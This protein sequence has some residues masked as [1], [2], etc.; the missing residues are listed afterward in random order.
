MILAELSLCEV[1]QSEDEPPFIYL[2]EY[3]GAIGGVSRDFWNLRAFRRFKK[4]LTER[5]LLP[6]LPPVGPEAGRR[7]KGRSGRA[8]Q[9]A[10]ML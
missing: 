9:Q 10:G 7:A 8:F 6:R 1:S 3:T 4:A 2:G 5:H